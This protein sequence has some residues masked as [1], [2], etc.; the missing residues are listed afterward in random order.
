MLDVGCDDGSWALKVAKASGA[1]A[2]YGIVINS[3]AAERASNSGITTI[4]QDIGNPWNIENSFF[5]LVHANQVIEHVSDVD[6]FAGEIFR[7]LRPGG[8]II[9]STENASSWH[10]IF[11]SILG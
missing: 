9:I 10:N 7:V 6:H 11:A 1:S 8:K 5:D 4:N 2:I 3:A